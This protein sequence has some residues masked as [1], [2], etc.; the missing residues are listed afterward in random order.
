[1]TLDSGSEGERNQAEAANFTSEDECESS[2]SEADISQ[3]T[4]E[5]DTT[6]DD[7]YTSV[8]GN[9]SCLWTNTPVGYAAVFD[10]GHRQ[11]MPEHFQQN[12][13]KYICN[14]L[15]HWPCCVPYYLFSKHSSLPDTLCLT[16]GSLKR[17]SPLQHH[18]RVEKSICQSF[19][20]SGKGAEQISDDVA[21]MRETKTC[22]KIPLLTETEHKHSCSAL[23]K[24]SQADSM[25]QHPGRTTHSLKLPTLVANPRAPADTTS[26]AGTLLSVDRGVMGNLHDDIQVEGAEQEE[27]APLITLLAPLGSRIPHRIGMR[28]KAI[29][30][31]RYGSDKALS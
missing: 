9:S 13:S 26:V 15:P 21:K 23:M 28:F 16:P 19:G 8:G 5:T 14:R 1:M 24:A 7:D 11:A 12:S 6:E 2:G 4:K 31:Q 20:G 18:K 29:A 30:H 22:L 17:M 10:A 27:V 3:G 25:P